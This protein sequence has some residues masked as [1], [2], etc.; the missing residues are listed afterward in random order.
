MDQRT[1]RA[2]DSHAAGAAARRALAGRLGLDIP[3]GWWPT[4]AIVKGIEA[5]GFAWV[6]VHAPPADVLVDRERAS[7]HACSLRAVLDT[8]SLRLVLHGPDT[9]S[10]GTPEADRALHGLRGYA[11]AAGA[12]IVV[13]H[14]ANF[15]LC[16]GGAAASGFRER[17]AAEERSLRAA[18][19]RVEALGLLLVIENL[20]PVWPGPPRL[21]HDAAAVRTLVRRTGSPAV[22]MLFDVGHAN[23][24]GGGAARLLGP[25]LADVGL[26][27]LHDNLGDRRGDEPARGG[28]DPLRLDL[29]LPPGAGTAPWHDLAPLLLDGAAPLV[30]EVPPP[31]RPDPVALAA[32]TAELLLRGWGAGAGD[33]AAAAA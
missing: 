14:G 26:F 3:R 21:C 15:A 23:I 22:R 30:L 13:Y 12:E 9:L 10:A 20:A 5:G 25:V 7:R 19:P 32:V 16:D 18:A 33:V 2:A 11:V 17:V 8:G 6:Q 4:P 28:L 31:H 27:H 29:H 24:V 1:E